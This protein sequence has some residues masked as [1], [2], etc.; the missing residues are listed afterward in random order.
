MTNLEGDQDSQPMIRQ[1]H[2][3]DNGSELMIGVVSVVSLTSG[4]ELL[5]TG[6]EKKPVPGIIRVFSFR[7]KLL[8]PLPRTDKI[9]LQISMYDL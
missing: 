4:L 7:V 8:F 6:R 2:D 5:K 1:R 3:C 9:Q